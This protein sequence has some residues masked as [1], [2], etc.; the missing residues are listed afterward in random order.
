MGSPGV[1]DNGK[2]ETTIIMGYMMG[3]VQGL[4]TD[5]GE[6]GNSYSVLGG[7]YIGITGNK[8]ETSISG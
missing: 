6:N 7:G 2:I 5:D 8:M 4:Y 1:R 3:Y